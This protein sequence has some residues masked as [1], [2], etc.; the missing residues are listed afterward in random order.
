MFTSFC[1]YVNLVY[2]GVQ[3]ILNEMQGNNDSCYSV[4]KVLLVIV[5]EVDCFFF[6]YFPPV[7]SPK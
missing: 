1:I 7:I 5:D 6:F 2:M 4:V 3:S